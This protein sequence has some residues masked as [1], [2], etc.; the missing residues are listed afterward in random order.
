MNIL[1]KYLQSWFLPI[2][3]AIIPFMIGFFILGI[4]TKISFE[5]SN[6][7][8]IASFILFLISIVLGIVRIFKKDY[9]KGISQT[10]LSIGIV[11]VGFGYL[12]FFLMFYP[13]D[14]FTDEL[15]LP[16]NI[17]LNLPSNYSEKG[18]KIHPEITFDLIN[19][20]QPGLYEYNFTTE[21]I[22]S[23]YI[24]LKAFE[25]TKNI[26]LSKEELDR[27]SKILVFN[28]T[29]SLKTFSTSNHFTIYE[30]DWDKPY[31]A[32]FEIWYKK[33]NG[34]EQKLTEKNY[35]IIGWQR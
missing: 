12:S 15:E 13:N 16:K 19:S 4:F 28:G 24:Y 5:I 32:R 14:F 10:I 31:G 30:G 1:K 34:E 18:K 25:I 33:K 29:D 22:D 7:L 2:L 11:I 8:F 3:I 6:G 9:L 21:K 23:G 26:R 27:D 35:K 20:F 17:N